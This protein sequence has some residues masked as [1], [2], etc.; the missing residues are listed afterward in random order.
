MS[1]ID[2]GIPNE[3]VLIIVLLI[4]I[5][6]EEKKS[7]PKY[8]T[9]T[10]YGKHSIIEVVLNNCYNLIESKKELWIVDENNT[11]TKKGKE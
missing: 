2:A 7:V 9:L 3:K 6:D 5:F 4:K 8:K 11:L 1:Y 10:E